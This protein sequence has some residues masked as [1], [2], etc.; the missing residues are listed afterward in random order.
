MNS[1][2]KIE[3]ELIPQLT[4]VSY[5]VL[6]DAAEKAARRN[7]IERAMVLGN[8]DKNKC[9]INFVTED[10][11][12]TVETTVWAATDD[13]LTLKGGVNIPVHCIERV[14]LI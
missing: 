8:A 10:G 7:Q 2:K 3:K 4:F 14:E 5:E 13:L 1:A 6:N 12:M 9:K 11:L